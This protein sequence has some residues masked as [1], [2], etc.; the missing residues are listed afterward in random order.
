MFEPYFYVFFL[1]PF[2]YVFLKK[3]HFDLFSIYIVFFTYYYTPVFYS[4]FSILGVDYYTQV[5]NFTTIYFL[6]LSLLN[7][8]AIL[9]FDNYFKLNKLRLEDRYYNSMKEFSFLLL[10]I[11]LICFLYIALNSSALLQTKS[12]LKSSIGWVLSINLTIVSILYSINVRYKSY[13]PSILLF[14]TAIL[15]LFAGG[16]SNIVFILLLVMLLKSNKK[17]RLI[18]VRNA[19][20]I[21]ALVVFCLCIISYKLIYKEIK[22]GDFGAILTKLSVLDEVIID[23]IL[24]DPKTVV[25]NFEIIYGNLSFDLLQGFKVFLSIFPFLSGVYSNIVELDSINMSSYINDNFI[26]SDFGFATSTFGE[27]YGYF[28]YVGLLV[29]PV[30]LILLLYVCNRMYLK[31]NI[32]FTSFFLSSSVILF[33]YMHRN[34]LI[35]NMGVFKFSMMVFVSFI[36][37][38]SI[39]KSFSK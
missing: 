18:S 7:F 14:I 8:S 32:I 22:A 28:G 1:I 34:T 30:L 24:T 37:Y 17:V 16:R 23:L 6:A 5:S 33:S 2:I 31:G 26:M 21:V 35:I 29:F 12:E 19:K 10:S 4:G 15:M 11:S 25:M 20:A 39:R 9:I 3:R 38:C 13:I 27:V 36:F